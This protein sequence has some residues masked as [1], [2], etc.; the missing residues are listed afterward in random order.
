MIKQLLRIEEITFKLDEDETLLKN[1]II[2][3]L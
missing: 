3:I 1:K 2:N